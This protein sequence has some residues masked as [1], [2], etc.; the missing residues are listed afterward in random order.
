MPM[1]S[2][3]FSTFF[4][5]CCHLAGASTR[6]HNKKRAA[7]SPI[8]LKAL[9]IDIRWRMLAACRCKGP[10]HYLKSKNL[11]EYREEKSVMMCNSGINR[12]GF[13]FHTYTLQRHRSNGQHHTIII[14]CVRDL[15]KQ[16]LRY[17]YSDRRYA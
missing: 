5:L 4:Y 17:K 13:W 8:L 9:S 6:W 16:R 14:M 11:K 2:T 7:L 1:S 15:Y 3:L 12:L 10:F